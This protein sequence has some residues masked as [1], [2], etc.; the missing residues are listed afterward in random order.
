MRLE[1]LQSC[2][3]I[4]KYLQ[5]DNYKRFSTV[6]IVRSENIRYDRLYT[7]INKNIEFTIIKLGLRL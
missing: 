2:F 1:I 5:G 4:K 3:Q 6:E 7:K